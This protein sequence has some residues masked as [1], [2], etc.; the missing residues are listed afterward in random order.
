MAS[1]L[2]HT[3]D[4]SGVETHRLIS[5]YPPPDFVKAASHEQLCGSDGE[6]LPNHVFADPAN[7]LYPCH[8]KAAT[9]M[10]LLFFM[11]K[12]AALAPHQARQ[13]GQAIERQGDFFQIRR[14]LDML[15]AAMAAQANNEDTALPDSMF[16]LVWQNEDGT[17]ERHYRLRNDGEIKFAA[18]WFAKYRDEFIF[19]DRHTMAKKILERA[20]AVG[21]DTGHTEMLQKTAGYGYCAAVTAAEA[22]EKRAGLVARTD[23]K[24]AEQMRK[25]GISARECPVETR[26][27]GKRLKLAEL[28]DQFDRVMHLDRLYDEGGLDRPEEA[29]FQVTEKVARDFLAKHVQLTNGTVYEKSALEQ[30]PVD[31]LRQWM[32][33]DLVSEV[34]SDGLLVDTAKLAAIVSTLPRGDADMFDRM[35][36]VAGLPVFARDKAAHATGLRL[37]EMAALAEQYQTQLQLGPPVEA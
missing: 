34:A 24:A 27:L 15:K 12:H 29:L 33:D 3:Q 30:L 1:V 2:D 6:G 18:D 21:L 16:A 31:L 35:A 22:I 37:D 7:R 26:D 9:W 36:E 8:T 13:I 19:P 14:E 28:L 25:L 23:P 10:S 17:K 4:L 11:D 5:L 20:D 32:G